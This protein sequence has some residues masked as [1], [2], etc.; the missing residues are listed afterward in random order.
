MCVRKNHHSDN[1]VPKKRKTLSDELQVAVEES[2]VAYRGL[3][4]VI[5]DSEPREMSFDVA[6]DFECY[7]K[8]FDPTLEAIHSIEIAT[9]KIDGCRSKTDT[10]FTEHQ[11]LFA[12]DAEL[13]GFFCH[14]DDWMN[15]TADDTEDA[16]AYVILN[17]LAKNT[18]LC[19]D[20]L[21]RMQQVVQRMD[22]QMECNLCFE[23]LDPKPSSSCQNGHKSCTDCWNNWKDACAISRR[24]WNCPECRTDLRAK[25]FEEL[26]KVSPGP[27]HIIFR[28]SFCRRTIRSGVRR[29]WLAAVKLTLG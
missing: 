19:I 9:R 12:E 17:G 3:G 7:K 1:S 23:M 11:Y 18:L 22:S 8:M 2:N 16:F 28:S 21:K 24:E 15:S 5:F 10:I 6:A 27:S 13:K 25:V 14:R 29:E 20:M 26:V 4:A